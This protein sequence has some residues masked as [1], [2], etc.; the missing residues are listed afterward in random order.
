MGV[1]VATRQIKTYKTGQVR[2]KDFN[3]AFYAQKF[4]LGQINK[5][6]RVHSSLLLPRSQQ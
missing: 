5:A 1:L 6:I 3:G 4:F 2:G